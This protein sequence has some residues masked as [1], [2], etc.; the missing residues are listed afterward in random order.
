MHHWHPSR[1]LHQSRSL[2]GH[3]Y[4]GGLAVGGRHLDNIGAGSYGKCVV[5]VHGGSVYS[6]AV[7]GEDSG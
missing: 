6:L 3:L 1:D 2:Y 4:S 7:G 5:A